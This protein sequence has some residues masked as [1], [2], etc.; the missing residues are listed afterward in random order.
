MPS[1][2]PTPRRGSVVA[3][4][5]LGG[6]LGA[7]ARYA[8][9]LSTPDPDALPWAILAVNTVGCAAIG[10]LMVAVTERWD[11]HP[12]VRPFLGIGVLGG[13]TSFSAYAFDVHHL[14]EQG[15]TIVAAL[16]LAGTVVAA[17]TAVWAGASAA[18]RLFPGEAP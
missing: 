15:R 13:F 10:V 16:Y 4:V 17:M 9:G 7:L 14:L 5:A 1:A 8:V 6:G 18:R 2:H 3:V 12:L 11:A